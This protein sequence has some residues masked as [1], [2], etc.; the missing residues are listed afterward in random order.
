MSIRYSFHLSSV[1]LAMTVS[2]H[3]ATTIW[4][5]NAS[6]G[7]PHIQAYDLATGVASADFTAPHKDANRGRANGRGIAV[8]G[9]KIYYSLADTPNVYVTDT[10]S[11]ADLGIAF[12]T[13][14]S[15][16]INNLAWD[17][18]SLWLNSSAPG[19]ARVFQY[20][21]TGQLQKTLT[22]ALPANTNL[23]RDGLEVTPG[24]II[25][26]H[27]SVPYDIFDFNGNMQTPFFITATF[28]TTGI[29]FDGTNYIVSD[30]I[31][32]RLATYDTAGNFVKSVTLSGAAIPFGLMDLSAVGGTAPTPCRFSIGSGS[33][34]VG[35]G[36][37]SF[38][39]LTGSFTL[40][41]ANCT[42]GDTWTATSN[43][44][45]LRIQSGA[46]GNGSAT[47]TT[48]NYS[49]FT[50][51]TTV[52]RTATI[53]VAGQTFTVTQAPSTEP[54]LSRVVRALYQTILGREPD[55]SGFQFWTG[56]GAPADAN[57]VV[58]VHQ[59][60]D[61][62]Y[63]S[64]EF[65]GSGWE[66][67]SVYQA[68]MGRLPSLGEWLSAVTQLR[69]GTL[70]TGQ[71]LS[72]LL[73]TMS[74]STF[75]QQTIQNAYGRAA[76]AAELSNLTSQLNTN[77]AADPRLDFL[78]NTIFANGEFRDRTNQAWVTMLY[79]TI[80]VRDPD[81]GGLT[82]WVNVATTA[83]GQQGLYYVTPQPG[84]TYAM[85]LAIIGQAVPP[86]PSLLGFLGS[87]EFQNRIR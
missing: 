15:P 42:A 60:A 36:S 5:F 33:A 55:I 54:Q 49:M 71:L 21:P 19:D 23:A 66:T 44:P 87:P 46:S 10:V 24:G 52:A 1:L 51:T 11:H 74:N 77:T 81:T 13:P 14:L 8:V 20:S 59:M 22:L 2:A 35:S 3:A 48:I 41:A 17:G 16:G 39:S 57:G 69:K 45:M 86:N 18:T 7:N 25:A 40:T 62:F 61:G 53:T 73:G 34:A 68:A 12:T 79:F 50:N 58:M 28:R 63:T 78:N 9:T 76:T 64:P 56:A 65:Q 29:A 32:G 83:P 37:G 67:L 70:T 4:G 85:K 43:S 82:F 27:G 31:N 72:G 75:V 30:V 84:A 38:N 26:N 47:S 80:L 6:F